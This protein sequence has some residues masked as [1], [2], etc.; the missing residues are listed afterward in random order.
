MHNAV[1]HHPMNGLEPVAEQQSLSLANSP[2]LHAEHDAIWHGISLWPVGVS[3]PG[4]VP[5]QLPVHRAAQ[6]EKLR[7]P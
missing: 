4:C 3:C 2:S 5:S 6:Q 1:A 7:S